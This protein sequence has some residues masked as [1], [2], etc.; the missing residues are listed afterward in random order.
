MDENPVQTMLL[1]V[2]GIESIPRFVIFIPFTLIFGYIII[3]SFLQI[4]QLRVLQGRVKTDADGLLRLLS[5]V[6]LLI[7]ILIFVVTLLI[8]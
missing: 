8:L 5:Y 2:F 3:H 6:Y 1:S 7:Q 4:R